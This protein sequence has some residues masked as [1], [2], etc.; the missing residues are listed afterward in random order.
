MIYQQKVP[1][2]RLPDSKLIDSFADREMLSANFSFS[3][4]S[5]R[6]PSLL[7]TC[8]VEHRW[9]QSLLNSHHQ[10]NEEHGQLSPTVHQFSQYPSTTSSK[11]V[12]RLI[13][14]TNK[15]QRTKQMTF[16]EHIEKYYASKY[17][18]TT[19]TEKCSKA[20]SINTKHFSCQSNPTVCYFSF[21]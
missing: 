5:Y 21:K 6:K 4:R 10:Q 1:L 9:F 16:D 19:T 15:L 14:C 17:L 18:L 13:R 11:L 12:S 2:N 20:P 7:I 8:P 3:T